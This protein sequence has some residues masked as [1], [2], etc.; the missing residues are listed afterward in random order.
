MEVRKSDSPVAIITD[1]QKSAEVVGLTYVSN[2]MPGIQ[3]V[4]SGKH[5]KY[6][7]ANGKVVR[8]E[9]QLKRIKSLVIPPA[10]RNVW[11]C[12]KENGH[13]QATGLDD[14]GR[15]QY[16]YHSKWREVR[17]ETKFNRMILFGK[18]LPKI[19]AQVEK[20]LRLEGMPRQK[21]L[22]TIV[23]LMDTTFI[24]VGND[25]YA[26]ENKSYG[27]TTMRNKHAEVKG[28]KVRFQFRGKSAKQH[29]IDV[30][31]ARLA[32]IVRK[33]QDLPGQE[34]FCYINGDGTVQDVK[35]DDVN[36]YLREISGQE[37]TAKDFRTWAGT[38][39]AA[40]ELCEVCDF[41]TK[42]DIKK[43]IT[44]TVEAVAHKLG[45]TPAVCR[46]CYVHPAVLDSYQDGSMRGLL[47]IRPKKASKAGNTLPPQEAAVLC[48]LEQRLKLQQEPLQQKLQ[49]SLAKVKLERRG[50]RRVS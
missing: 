5:F 50:L 29:I 40:K 13:L 15:K 46:K 34:L 30:E 19:R 45:N 1:P 25:E 12:P 44:R 26:R 24:R 7:D 43:N 49:R 35:S 20:H 39:L 17:D 37:F 31:D 22:A 47:K 10:W 18:A 23:R 48:L 42:K 6:L 33:C 4:G 38:V 8:D 28:S 3:R 14:R 36:T 21:V 32:K 41:E 2:D 16:R 9:K 11:I 27:L